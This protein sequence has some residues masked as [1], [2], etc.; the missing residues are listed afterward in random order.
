MLDQELG[1]LY[2]VVLIDG[3]PVGGTDAGAGAE[4]EIELDGLD[5]RVVLAQA[6]FEVLFLEDALVV[7]VEFVREQGSW[8]AL[9]PDFVFQHPGRLDGNMAAFQ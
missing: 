4:G 7:D 9:P 2:A 5:G 1:G 8:K 6:Q 3:Q